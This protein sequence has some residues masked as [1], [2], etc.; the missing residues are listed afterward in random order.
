MNILELKNTMTEFKNS[1][2]SFNNRLSQ[3][4]EII[5]KLKDSPFEDAQLEE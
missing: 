3:A 4:E 1:I 2:E 5:N